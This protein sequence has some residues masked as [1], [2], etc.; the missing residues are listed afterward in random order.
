[1]ADPHLINK[2]GYSKKRIAQNENHIKETLM[3]KEKLAQEKSELH[4]KNEDCKRKLE[5]INQKSEENQVLLNK[6]EK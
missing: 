1:M 5:Q 2:L 3:Q 6:L 4:S